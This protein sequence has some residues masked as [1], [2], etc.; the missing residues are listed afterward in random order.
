MNLLVDIG[1]TRLKWLLIDTGGLSVGAGG[2]SVSPGA[3]SV[4]DGEPL[5][6][7]KKNIPLRAPVVST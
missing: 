7:L 3:S 6:T 1:N 5:N 2:L 4:A